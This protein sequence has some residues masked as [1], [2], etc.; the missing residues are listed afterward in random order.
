MANIG[1]D[2]RCLTANNGGIGKYIFEMCKEISKIS[3]HN[4]FIYN[5]KGISLPIKA[6]NWFYRIPNNFF[7]KK[8]KPIAWLKL[9]EKYYCLSDKID[10]YWGAASLI[11]PLPN[12]IKKIITIHDFNHIIVPNTMG[13]LN[14]IAYSFYLGRDINRADYIICNSMGTQEK[15]KQF[16]NLNADT[17][18]SPA[19]TNKFYKITDSSKIIAFR[20]KYNIK[21]PYLLTVSTWEPRKNLDLAIKAFLKI[22]KQPL[23]NNINLIMVG[24]KGWKY[25]H[26]T[27]ELKEE[28]GIKTIGYIEENDLPYFYSEALALLFPSKYEGFGMPAL[29][30]RACKC[31]IIATDIPEL[32]ESAGS[33]GIFIKPTTQSIYESII[34]LL[35]NSHVTNN[36]DTQIPSWEKQARKMLNIFN[37]FIPS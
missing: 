20:E 31:R 17:I 12:K 7:E 1:I 34:S 4:F 29:E 18:I 23:F 14:R 24:A 27:R 33:H 15:L 9:F 32:R 6:S 8:I 2:G 10:I 3:S 22:R 25:R 5:N 35:S 26:I 21:N 11:P 19:I 37:R 30:A 16:Y 13:T 36:N 28:N